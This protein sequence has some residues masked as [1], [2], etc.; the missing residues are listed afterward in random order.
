MDRSSGF[1]WAAIAS[2]AVFLLVGA[3]LGARLVAADATAASGDSAFQ[4]SGL[5]DRYVAPDSY[6]P[7]KDN[8]G[9]SIAI[10]EQVELCLLNYARGIKG[11]GPLNVSPLLMNSAKL[12]AD[13]ILRCEQFAHDAC[14]V[15]VRQHF[16]DVGYFRRGLTTSFGENLAWGGATAGSPRGALLGWL[17]S[18]KHRENLFKPEWTDQG[19]ALVYAPSF[20]GVASSR[21]WVSHFGHQG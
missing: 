16:S 17:D 11:V 20:R 8:L 7:G 15:D 6:C 10:E 19:I 14:G 4:S 18:P 5:W 2:V 9:A 21:I 12:K 13:D 3:Y 1:L